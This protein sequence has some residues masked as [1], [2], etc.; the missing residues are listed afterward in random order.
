MATCPLEKQFHFEP[1]TS[2]LKCLSFMLAVCS[3]GCANLHVRTNFTP[4][5]GTPRPQ[6][7]QISASSSIRNKPMKDSPSLRDQ[8]A[9]AFRKL[10]PRTRQVES[11]GEMY[12]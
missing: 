9:T 12:V 4:P 8:V 11:E 6:M 5:R 7:I 3:V 10:F 2:A 1:K